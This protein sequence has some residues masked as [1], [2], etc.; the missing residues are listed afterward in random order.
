[1]LLKML[2]DLIDDCISLI[3]EVSV[4]KS[5][6][7][8]IGTWTL[9]TVNVHLKSHYFLCMYSVNKPSTCMKNKCA[10]KRMF[11]VLIKLHS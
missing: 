9:P 10:I 8:L 1:M 5:A 3:R 2:F 6:R 4:F 7:D 11:A